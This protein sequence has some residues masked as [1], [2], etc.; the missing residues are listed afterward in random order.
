MQGVPLVDLTNS[1]C[2]V[3]ELALIVSR[4]NQGAM[5]FPLAAQP[6]KAA[7][8]DGWH[9]DPIEVDVKEKGG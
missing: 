6:D 7:Q 3:S 9:K 4:Q 5:D 1:D 8:F 2:T